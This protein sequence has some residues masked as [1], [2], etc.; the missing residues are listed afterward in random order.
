[1]QVALRMNQ[2]GGVTRCF[3]ANDTVPYVI[4]EGKDDTSSFAQRAYHPDDFLKPELKLKIG[5]HYDDVPPLRIHD[6]TCILFYR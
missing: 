5:K 4:F 1:V 2:T 3:R 6:D